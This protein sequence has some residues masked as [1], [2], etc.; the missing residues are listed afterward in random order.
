MTLAEAL[1]WLAWAGA[2]G[3]AHGRRRGAALGR[4]GALW[5]L[6]AVLDLTDEWPVPLDVLGDRAAIAA[7]VVVGTGGRQSSTAGGCNS[8]SRTSTKVTPGRSTPS[9]PFEHDAVVVAPE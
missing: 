4:F 7:L 6:A 2:S 9:M 1:A 8:P 3:G 5:V